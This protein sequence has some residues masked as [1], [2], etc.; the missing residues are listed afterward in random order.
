MYSDDCSRAIHEFLKRYE[1]FSGGDGVD[2]TSFETVSIKKVGHLIA[3]KTDSKLIK[4][5]LGDLTRHQKMTP[6]RKRILDFWI[7]EYSLDQGIDLVIEKA[8]SDLLRK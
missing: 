8:R 7:P 2:I 1:I 6:P 4:G 5:N 3:N